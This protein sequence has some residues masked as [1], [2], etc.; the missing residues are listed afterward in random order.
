[1]SEEFP[2]LQS[3][4]FSHAIMT[5]LPSAGNMWLG[6]SLSVGVPH[7]LVGPVE[8]HQVPRVQNG[9]TGHIELQDNHKLFCISPYL[10]LAFIA[11]RCIQTWRV[12][13]R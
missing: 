10:D 12:N 9:G 8:Q 5:F 13:V 4:M 7:H 2:S 3:P 6:K 11:E 1:V